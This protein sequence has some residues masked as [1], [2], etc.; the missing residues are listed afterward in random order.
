MNMHDLTHI[1]KLN[2]I[3]DPHTTLTNEGPYSKNN[4]KMH[5]NFVSTGSI[6]VKTGL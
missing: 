1:K 2:Q 6:R 4:L 5:L 3:G